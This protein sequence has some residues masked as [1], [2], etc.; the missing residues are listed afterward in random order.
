MCHAT[1]FLF[2]TPRTRTDLPE[3]CRKSAMRDTV[4]TGD[5]PAVNG[6]PR[7]RL[8]SLRRGHRKVEGYHGL[9]FARDLRRQEIGTSNTLVQRHVEQHAVAGANHPLELHVAHPRGD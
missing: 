2:A 8:L 3:S 6:P 7:S 1:L 4:G 9:P 5:S